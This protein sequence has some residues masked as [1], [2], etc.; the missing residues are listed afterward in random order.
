MS[1]DISKATVGV[2]DNDPYAVRALAD[3]LGRHTT[4]MWSTS[5]VTVALRRC[6]FDDDLPQVVVV[7]VMMDGLNGLEFCRRVRER[8]SRPGILL[9]T[10]YPVERYIDQAVNA[11]AQGLYTK[12]DVPMMLKG[13]ACVSQGKSGQPELGFL[14]AERAWHES[15]RSDGTATMLSQRERTVI[16]MYARGADTN[17]IAEQLGVSRGTVAT[18]ERR[19]WQKLRATTRAQ[20]TAIYERMAVLGAMTSFRR[21]ISDWATAHWIECLSTLAGIF[22]VTDFGILVATGAHWYVVLLCLTQIMATLS[23]VRF[24]KVGAWAVGLAWCI[25]VWS[26]GVSLGSG[27]FAFLCAVVILAFA[28]TK[29]GIALLVIVLMVVALPF[30]RERSTPWASLVSMGTTLFGACLLGIALRW[31]MEGIRHAVERAWE[32]SNRRALLRLHDDISNGI[33][34]MMLELEMQ[35]ATEDGQLKQLT[36][37]QKDLGQIMTLL[38]PGNGDMMLEEKPSRQ[39][40][41]NPSRT[42]EDIGEVIAWGESLLESVGIRG[43]VI[44]P[45]E[46]IWLPEDKSA[47]AVG[48]I[49]EMYVNMAKYADAD[50][51]Y[52]VSVL[53]SDGHVVISSSNV[54]GQRRNAIC[55]GGRGL[56]SWKRRLAQRGCA[57]SFGLSGDRTEWAISAILPLGDDTITDDKAKSSKWG[58]E[59]HR[60]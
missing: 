45:S 32:A 22:G 15:L 48:L 9:V 11:G 18:Y 16:A 3:I 50:K 8:R 19:A 40:A 17:G 54:R 7:D 58:M 49:K 60:W 41:M 29:Q 34:V 27:L 2:V 23:M 1:Q 44:M 57:L 25:E 47:L 24:P 37:I 38:E 36:R 30:V 28:S 14:D 56:D 26:P 42:H 13:I 33:A 6:L 59:S 5:S 20:A 12:T 52:V 51:G 43:T 10:S 21:R 55:S 53:V 4:M 31:R 46:R 35:R 39:A